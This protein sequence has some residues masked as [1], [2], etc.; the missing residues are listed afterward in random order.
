MHKTIS[1]LKHKISMI[2]DD[3]RLV[4]IFTL[5]SNKRRSQIKYS[6]NTA[7]SKSNTKFKQSK[8]LTVFLQKKKRHAKSVT[9]NVTLTC[10]KLY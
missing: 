4:S 1:M 9:F 10:E 6:T 8:S 2:L 7:I 3:L 5:V